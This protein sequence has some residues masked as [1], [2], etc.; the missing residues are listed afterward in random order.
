M[1]RDLSFLIPI[2]DRTALLKETL[3]AYATQTADPSRS[4][5]V[6]VDD[7][8]TDQTLV[9]LLAEFR[10]QHKLN[11]RYFR[12]DI[13]SL[14]FPI[15]Q[16]QGLFNDPAP[17]WNIAIRQARAPRVVLTSPEV[18]PLIPE[19]IQ[20]LIDWPL[21]PK[22]GLIANVWDPD[23]SM[24]IG[25]GPHKRALHF[26]ALFHRQDLIDMGG[27]D[28][29][30]IGGWG[31]QD[32]DFH[33]RFKGPFGGQFVFCGQHIHAWHQSHP[34]VENI[35]GNGVRLGQQIYDSLKGQP[36][37]NAGH[38]WGNPNLIV[39]ERWND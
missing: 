35:D 26:L 7:G 37:A 30:F 20:R 32:C 16:Y 31:F 39:E 33:D 14:P 18:K 10:E 38:D 11:I 1:Q 28:E 15:Y 12:I 29:R 4:E 21:G 34:R 2:C 5:F 9:P 19:C 3:K 23:L 22:Q 17:A 6:I 25:G 24:W 27:M 8:G 36:V 13:R